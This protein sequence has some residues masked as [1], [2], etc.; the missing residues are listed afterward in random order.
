MFWR[1]MDL[2]LL[3]NTVCLLRWKRFVERGG[4]M[5]IQVIHH[6][7]DFIRIGV[8]FINK[9]LQL[10]RPI[11]SRSARISM[12]FA[13]TAQRLC[14]HKYGTRALSDIFAVVFFTMVILT[15]RNWLQIF[16]QKLKRLFIHADHGAFLIEG[17]RI[18]LKD[19]L[20]MRY[21]FGV[22]FWRNTPHLL[23][24]RLIFRFFK[25]CCTLT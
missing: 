12:R 16:I 19:V 5:C 13:P 11:T 14:E 24:V 3:R 10:K 1:V 4:S 2:K 22:L 6:Q 25:I 17:T 18:Y 23:Q 15:H 7:N 20:H 8:G 21:E 9:P